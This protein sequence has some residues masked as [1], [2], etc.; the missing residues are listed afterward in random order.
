METLKQDEV[1]Q[2]MRSTFDDAIS[3]WA[4]LVSSSRVARSIVLELDFLAL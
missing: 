1:T 3:K 4:E 2:F